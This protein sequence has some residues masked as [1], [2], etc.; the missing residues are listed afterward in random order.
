VEQSIDEAE[1][2]QEQGV[3]MGDDD[4]NE[5]D[6]DDEESSRDSGRRRRRYMHRAGSGD[7]ADGE[8]AAMEEIYEFLASR[9]QVASLEDGDD[10]EEEDSDEDSAEA[11]L[12]NGFMGRRRDSP[13]PVNRAP[14]YCP[15]MRHG[16]CINTAAWLDTGWRLSSV[17][18]FGDGSPVHV[19]GVES[20][21]CPTQ[22]VTSGDDHLL[23]FW[24]VSEA[25]GS[26]SPFS[27]GSATIC[28]FSASKS[29]ISRELE[30]EW[31][32]V[33][34]QRQG[35]R[36]KHSNEMNE[37]NLPGSV[38][39]MS[40]IHTGHR[41]NVFHVT[42]VAGKAGI[43]ATCGADGFLRL[44]DVQ[45]EESRIVVSPD[46]EDEISGMLPVGLLSLRSAMCYSHHFM[47][48]NV[49][50]LCSERGLKRFDL[51]LPPREQ[52]T[53]RLLSGAPFRT[54]KACAILSAPSASSTLAGH[55]EEPSYVFG[56]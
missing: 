15:S 10:D 36:A 38:R 47:N 28:P 23:K 11:Q 8:G 48:R 6:N 3:S 52:S 50:L 31:Q 27:G 20:G 21:E 33:Y 30:E 55:D 19:H 42:P 5:D 17:S 16:G 46:Y 44:T 22:L 45:T 7:D 26:V 56:E 39:L 51:R 54:C 49:G 29:R 1:E 13:A 9:G 43:V 37:Y 14:H 25:M 34:E 12:F 53:Q 41:G 18:D 35:S 4:E 24:D 2:P 32:S 40:T